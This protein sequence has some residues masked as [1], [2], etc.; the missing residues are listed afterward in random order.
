VMISTVEM[1]RN[2]E[3]SCHLLLFVF[4]QG[5]LPRQGEGQKGRMRLGSQPSLV[6]LDP[7]RY[8]GRRDT[9]VSQARQLHKGAS[10]PGLS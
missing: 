10:T 6:T 2:R 5:P 4:A 8:I 7:A 3:G 1:R 9:R